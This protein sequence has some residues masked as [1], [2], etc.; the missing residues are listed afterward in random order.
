MLAL[1][2]SLRTSPPFQRIIFVVVPL[3]HLTGVIGL[4]VPL[5]E[6]LFKALVPFHLLS[7]LALLLI[8]HEDWNR[9]MIIFCLVTY[10]VGFGI[11]ALGV[12]TGVIF[13]EYHYG[14]TLGWKIIDIPFTIG[15]NW[16]ALIYSAGIV[17]NQWNG[18]AF[19]KILLTAAG[20]VL[21]DVLIEPVAIRLDFWTWDLGSIPLQN[22]LAW[23]LVSAGLLWL[24]QLSTFRKKNPLAPLFLGSQIGFFLAHNVLF[25]IK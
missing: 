13:G 17:M 15:V 21:I 19:I 3:M 7:S 10:L 16:L 20:V 12:H 25:I 8:F 22:Y 2:T 14:R 5:T 11:E 1:L 6:P 9:S 4:Q 24:F 18:N 23:Y